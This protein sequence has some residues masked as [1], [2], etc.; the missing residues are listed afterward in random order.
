VGDFPHPDTLGWEPP[1]T[2]SDA[3]GTV[4]GSLAVFGLGPCRARGEPVAGDRQKNLAWQWLDTEF[5]QSLLIKRRTEIAALPPTALPRRR[6]V[7]PP[8]SEGAQISVA[9]ADAGL[10]DRVD[11]AFAMVLERD[12]DELTI[13]RLVVHLSGG[14]EGRARARAFAEMVAGAL[15]ER[16]AGDGSRSSSPLEGDQLALLK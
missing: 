8:D 12:F 11:E 5:G 13:G 16:G 10:P 6:R 14:Q 3:V 7:V 1:P 2:L 15:E 9:A 4:E